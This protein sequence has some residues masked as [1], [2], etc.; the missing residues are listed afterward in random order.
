MFSGPVLLGTETKNTNAFGAGAKKHQF[1]NA[2]GAGAKKHQ[3]IKKIKIR[4]I[5]QE[6]KTKK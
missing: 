3:F 2:F 6:N 4:Q 1:I 5:F